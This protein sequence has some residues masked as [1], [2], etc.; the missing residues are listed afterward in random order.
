MHIA[1]AGNIGSGKTTL[2]QLLAKH[3]GWEPRYETVVNNPYI[4][5]YYRNI[6]RWS[7]AMEVFYLKERFRDMLE[8][9]KAKNTIIQDRSIFEGVYVFAANNHNMGYLD[10]R[11]F[12]TYMELFESMMM[13]VNYPRLLIYLRASLQHLVANIE[14]RG[15]SFE[16]GMPIDYLENLN[17]LYDDFVLNKY[18]A[19]KLVIDVD[20]L[21]FQHNKRDLGRIVDQIDSELFGLFADSPSLS[22]SEK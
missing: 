21:D 13:R 18:P 10:D 19:P 1:I 8:I 7:F 16:Q 20:N 17:K 3:Y 5:D 14:N 12:S 4:E 2:T 22:N 15:R 6:P 9:A 11:D